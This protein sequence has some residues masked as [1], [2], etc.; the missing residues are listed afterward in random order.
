MGKITNLINAKVSGNVGAMSFRRRGADTVVAERAYTNSSKGNGATEAQRAH[1]CKLGNIVN[2]Y[3]VINKIEARAWEGKK[4]YVSDFN[5]LASLNLAG[6]P[7]YFTKDEAQLN[8]SVIAPYIVSRGS[9]EP[10]QQ[11]VIEGSFD[12]GITV[13]EGVDLE[14]STV[15]LVS[16][17]ILA[18]NADWQADDKLSVALLF[19]GQRTVSGVL[20]PIVECY[21][22]E[23]TLDVNSEVLFKDIPNYGTVVPALDENRHLLFNL[24]CD[25]AFAIHSRQSSGYLETSE[26]RVI[27]GNPQDAT[28]LKYGSQAQKEKA[29]SSYGYKGDVLLTPYSENLDNAG[30]LATFERASLNGVTI[31]NN[32][33]TSV[34]GSL[35]LYGTDFNSSNV[36]LEVDGV[37]WSPKSTG[38]TYKNYTLDNAGHFVVYANGEIVLQWT[39]TVPVTP[40][41]VTSMDINSSFPIDGGDGFDYEYNTTTSGIVLNASEFSNYTPEEGQDPNNFKEVVQ[42]VFRGTNLQVPVATGGVI[43]WHEESRDE[44]EPDDGIVMVRAYFRPVGPWTISMNGQV[45]LAGTVTLEY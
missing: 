8:A 9:L 33:T 6:S 39:A 22:F 10:L 16:Q 27:M 38:S 11:S 41:N 15:G 28:Y 34:R 5:M 32:G 14:T 20:I 44:E 17:A 45:L 13:A 40:I 29:M 18:N 7:I 19:Q 21:Y 43:T 31:A 42:L 12:S 36:Y 26:Q 30:A 37:R 25:A 1:R 4:P 2:F 24:G 35:V 3:R 23:M